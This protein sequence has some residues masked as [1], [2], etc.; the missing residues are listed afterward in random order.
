MVSVYVGALANGWHF[1]SVDDDDRYNWPPH[2]LGVFLSFTVHQEVQK[3]FSSPVY[4]QNLMPHI[5]PGW[6]QTG[7]E[8]AITCRESMSRAC[9]K[10]LENQTIAVAHT[11][12]TTH[13]STACTHHKIS[14]LLL[15]ELILILLIELLQGNLSIQDSDPRFSKGKDLNWSSLA[16]QLVLRS[17]G[18][19]AHSSS[20]RCQLSLAA[21]P[22]R[23]AGHNGARRSGARLTHR[24]YT[25]Y[26]IYAW[27]KWIRDGSPKAWIA[28]SGTCSGLQRHKLVQSTSSSPSQA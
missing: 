12:V 28:T 9:R 8:T 13:D 7:G 14:I 22:L 1:N 23:L 3:P 19:P 18:S 21:S 4:S 6:N 25:V 15:H 10:W 20:S 26:S 17:T 27:P 24:Y 2:R 16:W 5:F 11:T